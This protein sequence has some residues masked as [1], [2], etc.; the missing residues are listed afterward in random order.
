MN[1]LLDIAREP[2]LP[3]SL[4]FILFAVVLVIIAAVIVAAVIRNR[5]R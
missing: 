4:P 1:V 2:E 5:R 3:S